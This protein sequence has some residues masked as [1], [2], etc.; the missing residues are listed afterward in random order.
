MSEDSTFFAFLSEG[1][2]GKIKKGVQYSRIGKN[3]FNLSFGDWTEDLQEL[4]D[5]SRS[6]NGD[7]DK[8]LVTVA[9]TAMSFTEAF[10][11]TQI[12]ITG[13]TAARTR[14]YQMGITANLQEILQNFEIQGF[15]IGVWEPFLAGRNYEAFL[16]TRKYL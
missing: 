11:D 12:F 15:A 2:R 9:Y 5:S 16:F 4:D 1:P 8:V 13:S 3:L 10:P 7:R 14:L 6:N